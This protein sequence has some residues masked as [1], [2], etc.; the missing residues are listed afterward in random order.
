MKL[1]KLHFNVSMNTLD[2]PIRYL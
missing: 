2:R 1:N